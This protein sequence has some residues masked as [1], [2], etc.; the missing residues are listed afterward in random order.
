[1][2]YAILAL[3]I[4]SG[5]SYS[6]LVWSSSFLVRIHGLTVS[7]ASVWSGM[8]CGLLIFIGSLL[9]GP[10]ADRFSKGDARRLSLIP[11]AT[12]LI[13]MAGG[14]IMTLA[15]TL[16]PALAGLSLLSLMSGGFVAISY[17]L[18]LSLSAP[19]L[20]GKTMAVSKLFSTLLGNG[21]FPLITGAI[22]DAIG[23][24]GSIRPALLC[25]MAVLLIPAF[26]YMCVYKINPNDRKVA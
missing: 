16:T 4:A 10:F 22:S 23:G 18:V 3:T 13:A 9:V 5:V 24:P 25:T 1:L 26:C 15:T 2:C 6:V 14:T 11:M 17:S 21:P 7:D 8:A 12:V 19:Q 20:R